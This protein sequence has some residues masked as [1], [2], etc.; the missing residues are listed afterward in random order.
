MEQKNI[1]ANF[2]EK[3][4]LVGIQNYK[5]IGPNSNNMLNEPIPLPT[6]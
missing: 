4:F 3:K 2:K 5:H 6:N 1:Q